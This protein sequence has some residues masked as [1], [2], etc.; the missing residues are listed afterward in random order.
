MRAYRSG[1][2]VNLAAAL[3]LLL[4]T[5]LAAS[6]APVT[7]PATGPARNANTGLTLPMNL[8]GL[9][10]VSWT[11]FEGTVAGLGASYRYR[12]PSN[13]TYNV[14]L[15]IYNKRQNIPTGIDSAIVSQEVDQAV[16]EVRSAAA[17]GVYRNFEMIADKQLCTFGRLQFY[18][19]KMRFENG[20]RV[21][22]SWLLLRGDRGSFIKVRASWPRGDAIAQASVQRWATELAGL[23]Q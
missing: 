13:S 20:G 2:F 14:D 5:S 16:A 18:C 6:A 15:Y 11:D 4:A 1:L 19:V 17:Q 23:L 7:T 22:E 10:F 12:D 21:F 8:G 3:A 9:Q